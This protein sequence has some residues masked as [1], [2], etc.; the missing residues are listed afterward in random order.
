MPYLSDEEIEN[1]KKQRPLTGSDFV[2]AYQL[3]Y[4]AGRMSRD[5]EL[6]EKD[7]K[8]WAKFDEC[9]KQKERADGLEE[10]NARLREKVKKLKKALKSRRCGGE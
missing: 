7:K 1:L 2:D 5:S 9:S 6:A 10:E 3:G 8:F 4:D